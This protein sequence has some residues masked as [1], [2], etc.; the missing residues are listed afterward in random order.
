MFQLRSTYPRETCVMKESVLQRKQ[1]GRTFAFSQAQNCTCADLGHCSI[2]QWENVW[3]QVSMPH[4]RALP[5]PIQI[6]ICS[7]GNLR[8]KVMALGAAECAIFTICSLCISQQKLWMNFAVVAKISCKD[9]SRSLMHCQMCQMQKILHPRSRQIVCRVWW[10]VSLSGCSYKYCNFTW[11]FT[12]HIYWY[13][14]IISLY[15]IH[16]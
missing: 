1:V 10:S 2:L 6:Q 9:G 16:I 14:I 8:P 11:P 12:Y 5:S 3:T 13:L 4:A 15:S 7:S